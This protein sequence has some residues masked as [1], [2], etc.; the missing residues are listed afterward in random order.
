MRMIWSL[1]PITVAFSGCHKPDEYY[2][3]AQQAPLVSELRLVF[4]A[5]FEHA[6]LQTDAGDDEHP[7]EICGSIKPSCERFEESRPVKPSDVE[8]DDRDVARNAG[9]EV[10]WARWNAEVHKAGCD[11]YVGYSARRCWSSEYE[12]AL[13]VTLFRR[14]EL[15]KR[16]RLNASQTNGLS[17]ELT[18]LIVSSWT[19][20]RWTNSSFG[21][22]R[23]VR[24]GDPIEP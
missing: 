5:D 6:C 7:Q 18:G 10:E 14:D 20:N 19:C 24:F 12:R 17:G 3:G 16:L 4:Y 11:E 13:A 21:A 22:A 9:L 8:G 1:L 2:V 15:R 23:G